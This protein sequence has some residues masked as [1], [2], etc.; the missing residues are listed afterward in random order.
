MTLELDPDLARRIRLVVCDIDGTLVRDDKS[1]SEETVASVRRAGAAGIA[2]TVISA[3]PPS[4][5]GEIVAALGI[6]GAVGAFNGGTLFHAGGEVV[7]AHRLEPAD[8]R[9]TVRRLDEAGVP[10]WLFADGLWIARDETSPHA[11]L[12][13]RA[14]AQAPTIAADFKPWMDRVDKVVG[15]TDDHARLARLERE[16]GQALAPRANVVRSQPYFLDVTVARANKGDGLEALAEAA[17]VPLAETAAIGDM[18]NDIPMLRRAALG[19]AMGQ[20]PSEVRDAARFVTSSN[21]KNGVAVFLDRL[22]V[23]RRRGTL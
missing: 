1:L 23:G 4:G 5:L 14:A 12:E 21:E 7:E 10:V 20:A 18:A 6:R 3:R 22:L 17:G 13:R 9:E 8:A 19:V 2:V 11:P 16:I 15:V